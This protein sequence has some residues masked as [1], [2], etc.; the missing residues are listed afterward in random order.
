M[1]FALP[2]AGLLACIAGCSTVIGIDG[3]YTDLDPSKND[4]G[5]SST[6]LSGAG[7]ASS[8]GRNAGGSAGRSVSVGGD[9][10]NLGGGAGTV[11]G[12]AGNVGGG[13]GTVGGGAGSVGGGA[14]TV[15]GG[16]GSQGGRSGGGG[17]SGNGAKCAGVSVSGVCWYLGNLG[18][19]CTATCQIHGG[20]APSAASF[21]GVAAQGGSLTSCAT[22]L[23]ALGY[24]GVKPA[25]ASRSDGAGVGCH[26]NGTRSYWLSDPNY[27]PSSRLAG[28][29]VVC[30]CLG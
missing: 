26:V 30:G 2:C 9:A 7:G 27:S 1:R 21:V 12:G 22:L 15:G 3:N 4:G 29:Q 19:S 5:G 17:G 25:A 16:A 13:A 23:S 11:G 20:D 14:G 6:A 18:K 10:G 24:A 8:A 28:A